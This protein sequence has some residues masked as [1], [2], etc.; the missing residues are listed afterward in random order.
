M[1]VVVIGGGIVGLASAYF[2]ARRGETVTVLEQSSLGAGSTDRA[3]GGIRAQFT[4]PVS[5]RLSQESIAV[6]ERFEETFGVDIEY[7]R[8]GYL[9]LA[10]TAATAERLRENVGVQAEYGV[11]SQFLTPADAQDVCPRLHADRYAGA[12]YSPADGFADPHLGLEG[13]ATGAVDAGT[14]IRTNVAVTDVRFRDGRVQGVETTAGS[15]EADYVVNAAGAW[16]SRVAAMAGID[17]PVTP[18]RRQLV[19]VDPEHD[20]PRDVPLT[21]DM[22]ADSHFRPERNGRAVVGGFFAEE[23]PPADPDAYTRSMDF[24]WAATALE[25]VSAVAGYFGPESRIRRGWAGLYAVT[26]DHHPV[27]EETRPGFVNAVGFSGHGFMQAPATGQVVAEIVA[28]GRASLVNVSMLRAD[29]FER[30]A[31]LAEGTVID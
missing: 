23:D 1:S 10:R 15:F 3:N 20:V 8:P 19:V 5:I 17:L 29:R 30:G 2:L 4:S 26:P 31:T 28:D 22:D 11:P 12:T 7:T 25:R 16:G 14:D 18:K 9:F 24:D 21:V 27:I 6:W 13:F